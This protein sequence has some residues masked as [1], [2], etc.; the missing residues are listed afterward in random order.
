MIV[1]VPIS[2]KWRIPGPMGDTYIVEWV[3]GTSPKGN[4]VSIPDSSKRE[5]G[6]RGVITSF[7]IDNMGN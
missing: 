1:I 5:G 7:S 3:K 2:M 4:K 6:G